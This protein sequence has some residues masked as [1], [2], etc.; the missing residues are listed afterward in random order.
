MSAKILVVDDE[1]SIVKLV[2]TT[3]EARGYTVYPAYDGME[4][5]TEAKVR[6]PDL[7]L[8]DIMMPHMDGREARKRLLA[9]PATAN[10]PVIH[11]SAVGDFEQ[12]L[13]ATQLGV[14]GYITKP[15]TPSDL[16][17]QV[18]DM[19]D[20][21]KRAAVTAERRK[22]DGKLRAMVDIMHRPPKD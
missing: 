11:L 8:L 14:T 6:K 18:A 4:C 9:D 5:L 1:P 12:Q 2:T 7:I 19:L 10:I 20:P 22:Q 17:Q 3:L 21:T 16:A 13:K 15:F